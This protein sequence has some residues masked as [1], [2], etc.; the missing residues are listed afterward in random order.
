MKTKNKRNY[1]KE[2]GITLIALVVTI[3]VLLIL[4]G[5]TM[6]AVFGDTGII[7]KAQDAQSKMNEAQQNDLKGI[8]EVEKWITEY[9]KKN[10]GTNTEKNED[11]NT[12]EKEDYDISGELGGEYGQAY[13]VQINTGT[14]TTNNGEVID[15][16]NSEDFKL[17]A[18]IEKT[19]ENVKVEKINGYDII[20]TV[21]IKLAEVTST[22]NQGV[23]Y[24]PGFKQGD[25]AICKALI[26]NSWITIETEI[27]GDNLLQIKNFAQTANIEFLKG[28]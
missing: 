16:T 6:N 19:D 28:E 2:K 8:N 1:L 18:T 9:T 3:V 24:V 21:K 22:I 26:N 17:Y 4:A 25:S 12:E 7:K 23:I 10:E 11:N 5:V 13:R 15:I 27:I 14:V 20:G